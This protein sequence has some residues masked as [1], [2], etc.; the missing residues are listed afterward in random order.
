MRRILIVF[1]V[2]CTLFLLVSVVGA[3]GEPDY[4]TIEGPGFLQ[5]LRFTVDLGYGLPFDHE[6]RFDV[7]PENLGEGFE[8]RG[9]FNTIENLPPGTI[10]ESPMSPLIYYPQADGSGIILYIGRADTFTEF[11]NHYYDTTPEMERHVRAAIRLGQLRTD[12]HQ[13]LLTVF[14]S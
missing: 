5:P 12:L 1:L 13:L 14:P 4:F 6:S 10:I 11:D 9:Y 3:K 8:I 2:V 7:A